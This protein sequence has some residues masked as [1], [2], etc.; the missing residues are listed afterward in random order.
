MVLSANHLTDVKKPSLNQ[1]KLQHV[2]TQKT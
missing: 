1:I 2:T